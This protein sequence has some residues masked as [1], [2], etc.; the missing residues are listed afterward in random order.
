MRKEDVYPGLI[1]ANVEYQK[2]M[3]PLWLVIGDCDCP[4]GTKPI[5][6]VVLSLGREHER[7]ISRVGAGYFPIYRDHIQPYEGEAR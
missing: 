7:Q 3:Q 4:L 5:H 2:G 6:V 1:V